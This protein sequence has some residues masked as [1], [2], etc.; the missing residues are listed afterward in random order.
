MNLFGSLKHWRVD[1]T[2]RTKRYFNN[3]LYLIISNKVTI[4]SGETSIIKTF[5]NG[6]GITL[7]RPITSVILE[8]YANYENRSL[9]RVHPSLH[10]IGD[11]NNVV[12]PIIVTNTEER[13]LGRGAKIAYCHGDFYEFS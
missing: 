2:S 5:A 13:C 4:P 3:E 10:D 8:G 6:P 7:R 12:I 11:K 9:I 1:N